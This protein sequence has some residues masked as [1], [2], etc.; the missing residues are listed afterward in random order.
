MVL[1]DQWLPLVEGISWEGGG[2]GGLPDL[3]WRLV[4]AVVTH[5]RPI[6]GVYGVGLIGH[7]FS[8]K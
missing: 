1:K 2:P 4:Q 8:K 3:L 6:Y 7:T 5:V